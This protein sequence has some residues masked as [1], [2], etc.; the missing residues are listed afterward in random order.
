MDTGQNGTKEIRP[1]LSSTENPSPKIPRICSS[2]NYRHVTN[3]HSPGHRSRPYSPFPEFHNRGKK[4]RITFIDQHAEQ[5]MFLFKSH[6]R[7]MFDVAGLF[8]GLRH[9]I[10]IYG[11]SPERGIRLPGGFHRHKWRFVQGKIESPVLQKHIKNWAQERRPGN[12]S[13]L[14]RLSSCQYSMQFLFAG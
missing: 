10:R 8:Y 6:Y 1:I 13:G 12:R 11:M 9:S 2:H 3:G 7:H 5:E 14:F 4:T